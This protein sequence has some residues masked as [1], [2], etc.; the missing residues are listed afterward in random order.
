VEGALLSLQGSGFAAA[1]RSSLWLYPTANVVHIL[2]LL[3]FFASVAA[4]DVRILRAATIADARAF[5][6]RVRPVAIVAFLVQAGSGVMLLAPE[7]SHIAMNPIFR[8]KLLAI[9]VGLANVLLLEWLV[10]RPGNEM[11]SGGLRAV[12][13]TSLA[14]WLTAA[15]L[16]RL[17]AYF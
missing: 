16:G 6:T 13:V 12:A 3:V 9:A 5:I 7:A 2:A 17:I 15:A 1:M 11:V 4:M 10:R 14:I 8:I